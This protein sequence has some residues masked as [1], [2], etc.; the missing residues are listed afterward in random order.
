MKAAFV[1]FFL[2]ASA[3]F[4]DEALIRHNQYRISYEIFKNLENFLNKIKIS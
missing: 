2:S 3:D 4:A 1:H